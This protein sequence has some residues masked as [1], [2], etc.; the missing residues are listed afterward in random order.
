MQKL[1]CYIDETGQDT[2]GRLFVVAAVI[3][4]ANREHVRELLQKIERVSGK[5]K[6]KWTKATRRQRHTYMDQVVQTAKLQG[7]LFYAY[8]SHTTNY[9]PCIL[10]TPADAL[11]KASA[12]QPYRATVLIASEHYFFSPHPGHSQKTVLLKEASYTPALP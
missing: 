9:L 5:G 1:Y 4:A 3:T 6:K 2:R 12:G 8:F 7:S 11:T 10:S